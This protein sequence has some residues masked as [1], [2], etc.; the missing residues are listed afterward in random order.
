MHLGSLSSKGQTTIPIEIREI[1]GL[2]S[3]D[4]LEFFTDG[5]RITIIPINK[6]IEELRGFLNKP[7][8][9]FSLEEMDEAIRKRPV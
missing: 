3:G 6:S 5:S 2:Q 1:L 4:K 7:S 8:K 9:S